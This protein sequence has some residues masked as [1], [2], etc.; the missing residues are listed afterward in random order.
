[1]KGN[2][3]CIVDNT[4]YKYYIG[5]TTKNIEE[6]LREHKYNCKKWVMGK[7]NY[8]TSY[9][10]LEN[11]NY[12]IYLIKELEYDDDE[13][14]ELLWLERNFI[15]DGWREGNCVNKILPITTEEEK[16]EQKKQYKIENR[17]EIFKKNKQYKIENRE[18]ILEYSI[19]YQKEYRIE[20]KD[21][22]NEKFICPCGGK[23]TY[24]HK[25]THEKTI[26]H[27]NYI[28]SLPETAPF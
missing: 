26:T 20:N 22:I 16:S 6:R 2:I 25:S 10:I 15:E 5:S 11:N 4:N 14:Y 17:E 27:K 9:E 18:K 7:T 23:Y 1:M 19:E 24:K 12:S 13:E 8:T 28:S 21:K 3:Y